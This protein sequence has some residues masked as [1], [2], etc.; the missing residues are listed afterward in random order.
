M[1]DL[2]RPARSA[3]EVAA[4]RALFL[5]YAG[6]LGFS[7]DFQDFA[8]EM[9]AFPG[10]YAPPGG[11]L[12][13]AERDGAIVGAVGLR[14]L[15]DGACEMKR[16]YLKPESRRGGL[17]RRLAE[18]VVA[19]GRRL[20]YRAMRLD[21][22]PSMTAALALYRAMGF[23]EIAPYYAGNPFP[24]AVYLELDYGAG[25]SASVRPSSR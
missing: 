11:A 24:E 10:D 21:T 14:D 2:V 9:A 22:L 4:A 15:G 20:G 13:V 17:G 19:E 18:A 7:L 1:T 16:L 8:G 6:T 12:L 5:D 23:R 3:P 25:N